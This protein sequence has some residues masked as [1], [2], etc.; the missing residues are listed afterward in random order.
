[1]KQI[2]LG[3]LFTIGIMVLLAGPLALMLKYKVHPYSPFTLDGLLFFAGI[4][5][6]SLTCVAILFA[7]EK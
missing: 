6:A 7:F 5:L 1:M 4:V 3:Y 2:V